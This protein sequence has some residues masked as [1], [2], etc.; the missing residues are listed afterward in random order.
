MN[1]HSRSEIVHIY[2]AHCT[3]RHQCLLLVIMIYL[4]SSTLH[5]WITSVIF[6]DNTWLNGEGLTN[7]RSGL[8]NYWVSHSLE[9]ILYSACKRPR[10][11]VEVQNWASS[12]LLVLWPMSELIELERKPEPHYLSILSTSKG[13]NMSFASGPLI[14]NFEQCS[15]CIPLI[16]I[17]GTI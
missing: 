1:W 2:L 13:P 15:I 12:Q 3:F 17:S 16:I 9:C 6:S 5:E 8:C 11:W 10:K 7:S 14:R 4:F